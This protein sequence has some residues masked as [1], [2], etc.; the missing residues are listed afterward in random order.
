MDQKKTYSSA[1]VKLEVTF[2][3]GKEKRISPSKGAL[4]IDKETLSF[5]EK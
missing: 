1:T 4:S 5:K 3:I 2:G